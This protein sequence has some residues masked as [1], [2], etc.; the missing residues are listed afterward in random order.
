MA[1]KAQVNSLK[2]RDQRYRAKRY[3]A[4]YLSR[5]LVESEVWG[6]LAERKAG[7][8]MYVYTIFL[9]KRV[10]EK[11]QTRAGKADKDFRIANNGEIQFTYQ[12]A[13]ARGITRPRFARAIDLLVLLGLIDI[14]KTGTGLH[15]DVTLYAI[16]D[17][18]EKYGTDEFVV[19]KRPKRK[20]HYGFQ[21]GR[22]KF[23]STHAHVT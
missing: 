16:S 3:D 2:S 21:K 11:I 20:Q 10:M 7:I 6:K 4:M 13:E 1:S 14:A 17:R 23:F 5:T 19:V 8:A 18:W 12:E 22:K 15:R 9:T